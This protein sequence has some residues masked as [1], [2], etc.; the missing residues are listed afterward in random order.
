MQNFDDIIIGFGKGGK[1]IAAALA[2]K[3]RRVAMIEKSDRMYGGTCINIACIPTKTLVHEAKALSGCAERD[4]AQKAADYARA[5]ARKDEVTGFLR[6]KNLEMLTSRGVTVLTGQASFASPHEV[7]VRFADGHAE[8]LHGEDIYINT[9]AYSVIPPIE[10]LTESANVYTST[11]LLDL[12]R[13]P[14]RLVILGAG[15]IALEM[16][17]MYAKFGS[18]V[19]MLEYSRRFLPREDADMA[20][21]VRAALEAQGVSIHLGVSARSVRDIAEDGATRT[22]LRCRVAGPDGAEEERVFTADAVLLATGR[23]PLTEGLNLEAAGVRLDEHGAI[24]VDGRLRT[25]QPHIRALGDVKGGLQFTYISLDDFRIVRDALWGEGKRDT[26][27][28]GPVAYAVFMDPPLARVGL[29]EEE[30]RAQGLNVTI[31]TLPA[32]AI[33]RARL[34]GETSGLL[35]AVADADSGAILGCALHCADAGEM[36]NTD[37]A[38]M[39]AGQN[40]AFL[41]DLIYTH[42]SMTEALNDLFGQIS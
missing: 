30:A 22:E 24:A 1:T 32:A 40:S 3:G 41:R 38:A 20:Q 7:E 27:N 8:L 31:A 6:Q 33:P 19:T 34:L 5:V 37:T 14:R 35:K 28:R 16:A 11:S 2:G 26:G 39:R 4:F 15:Y 17:S 25:S 9:G 23:R 29:S 12:T 18:S 21:S 13:L 36:I 10:G 42:P